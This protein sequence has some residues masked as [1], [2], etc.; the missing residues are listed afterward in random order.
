VQNLC[1]HISRERYHKQCNVYLIMWIGSHR[2]AGIVLGC[3]ARLTCLFR[4]HAGF[5]S[6]S[7]LAEQHSQNLAREC[8]N[9]MTLLLPLASVY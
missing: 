7:F 6:L 2:H 5:W 8:D 4:T 1:A 9:K 3:A